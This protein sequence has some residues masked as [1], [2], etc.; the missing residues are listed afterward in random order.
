MLQFSFERLGLAANLAETLG[1]LLLQFEL[2]L[3]SLDSS[4]ER[5]VH[6]LLLNSFSDVSGALES[7]GMDYVDQFSLHEPANDGIELGGALDQQAGLLGRVR[8]RVCAIRPSPEV[9][10]IADPSRRLV[11]ALDLVVVRGDQ[12]RHPRLPRQQEA[13]HDILCGSAE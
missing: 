9:I 11:C 7:L 12:I 8:V 10:I 4:R 1:D 2:G 3:V 6:D 5:L 13:L